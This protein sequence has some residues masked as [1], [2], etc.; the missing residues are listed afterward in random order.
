MTDKPDLRKNI[1]DFGTQKLREEIEKFQQDLNSFGKALAKVT[2]RLD[3]L[4]GAYSR[5]F[6]DYASS[7]CQ[8]CGKIVPREAKKC[9]HCGRKFSK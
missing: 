6:P 1:Q 7:N 9:Q 4:E 3:R 2:I 5:R 8:F